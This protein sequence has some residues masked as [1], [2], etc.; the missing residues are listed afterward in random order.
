MIFEHRK[1]RMMMRTY[2]EYISHQVYVRCRSP[3]FLWPV[4]LEYLASQVTRGRISSRHC[5][6]SRANLV[7]LI[8]GSP[9]SGNRSGGIALRFCFH[10]EARMETT[11]SVIEYLSAEFAAGESIL[12]H[13]EPIDAALH[14]FELTLMSASYTAQTAHDVI[15][16][17]S[18]LYPFPTRHGVTVID[19]LNRKPLF[20]FIRTWNINLN[21]PF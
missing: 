5:Y 1:Y 8:W 13:D 15:D 2:S 7:V 17:Q 9:T 20:E 16:Q 21:S 10:A 19:P 12:L 4:W 18:S 3:G 14:F 6:F 11:L